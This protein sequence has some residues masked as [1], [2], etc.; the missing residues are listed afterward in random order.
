M[1][2]KSRINRTLY[3]AINL[4]MYQLQS[5]SRAKKVVYSV[6][7]KVKHFHRFHIINFSGYKNIK[8]HFNINTTLVIYLVLLNTRYSVA[9]GDNNG[10]LLYL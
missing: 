7:E 5:I 4:I 2:S 10:F 1:T 8:N 3:Q 6:Y 9:Y